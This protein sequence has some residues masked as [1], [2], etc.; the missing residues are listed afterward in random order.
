MQAY[1]FYNIVTR[2]ATWRNPRVP[3]AT[4][5]EAEAVDKQIAEYEERGYFD[6]ATGIWKMYD[7]AP[8][9]APMPFEVL[10]TTSHKRRDVGH[11]YFD[12]DLAANQHDGR[13]L[14]A[15]RQKQ[16]LSK[17]QVENF[18]KIRKERKEKHRREWLM[19]D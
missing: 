13:S 15:E 8:E 5:E 12:V 10:A 2:E 6:T 14:R 3:P 11:E 17:K 19:K 16:K 7:T 1:Y 9:A 18:R 4:K